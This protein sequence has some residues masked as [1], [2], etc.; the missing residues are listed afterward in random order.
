MR[1]VKHLRKFRNNCCNVDVA[2]VYGNY[3]LL[4]YQSLIEDMFMKVSV[5]STI[6]FRTL[7]LV[8]MFPQNK[9]RRIQ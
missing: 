5:Q 2:C 7:S 3:L 4:L 9:E 8:K 1:L 6:G